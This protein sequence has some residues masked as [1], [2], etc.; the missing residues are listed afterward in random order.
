MPP[1]NLTPINMQTPTGKIS[2]TEALKSARDLVVVSFGAL[3]PQLLEVLQAVDFGEY[4]LFA[5][6]AFSAFM[7]L[8][9][10]FLNVARV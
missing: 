10:R 8:V 4:Q 7:P 2:K 5:T 1:L 3:I 6:E 9:N